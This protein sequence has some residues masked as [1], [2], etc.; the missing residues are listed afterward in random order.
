MRGC[1]SACVRVP[2]SLPVPNWVKELPLVE[3]RLR[4][5]VIST[6]EKSGYM[7]SPH[8][9]LYVLHE[10]VPTDDDSFLPVVRRVL[11]T[12]ANLSAAPWGYTR[13]G[14]MEI[15]SF[16]LGVCVRPEQPSE[17][18]EPLGD[19]AINQ[20]GTAGRSRA[21]WAQAIPFRIGHGKKCDDPFLN[22]ALVFRGE[23][24]AEKGHLNY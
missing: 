11:L 3:L 12:S 14:Q 8:L 17:L 21:V 19:L 10:P 7:A 9:M 22:K 2:S 4:E 20:G 23:N 18:V 6:R 16:E 1:F 15:R 13:S 5:D 24:Q